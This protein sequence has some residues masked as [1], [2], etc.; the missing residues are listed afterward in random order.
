MLA[1]VVGARSGCTNGQRPCWRCLA[2]ITA[3]LF[4]SLRHTGTVLAK[5]PLA[6][7]QHLDSGISHRLG[8]S[9]AD[10]QP[11]LCRGLAAQVLSDGRVEVL[12]ATA[13]GDT[14]LAAV[15]A[16]GRIAYVAAQPGSNRTLH[17]KGRD[18]ELFEVTAAYRPLFERSLERFI[19]RVVPFGFTRETIL[20]AWYELD[21]P[22]LSGIRFTPFGAWDQT[23]GPGAGQPVDL[24]P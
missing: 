7:A 1:I 21:T 3:L 18:A 15:R 12:L 23:P 24:L 2:P 10:G 9:H 8:S 22:C 16:T 19:A 5:L 4:A 11:E 13:V 14:L 17:L 20:A 6:W